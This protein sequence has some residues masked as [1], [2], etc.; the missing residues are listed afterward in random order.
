MMSMI[1]AIR[2]ASQPNGRS[3]ERAAADCE[4]RQDLAKHRESAVA[5]PV[6]FPGGCTQSIDR[7]PSDIKNIGLGWRFNVQF[8]AVA[9]I[10]VRLQCW[11][12]QPNST[13]ARLA[14]ATSFDGSPGRRSPALTGMLRPVT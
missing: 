10:C 12:S 1:R 2:C 3:Y 14:S 8:Q 6:V 4:P 5:S 11:G 7:R 9:M 13:L